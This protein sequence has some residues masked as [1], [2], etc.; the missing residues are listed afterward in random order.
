MVLVFVTRVFSYFFPLSHFHPIFFHLFTT[1]EILEQIK[2]LSEYLGY[3]VVFSTVIS[4]SSLCELTTMFVREILVI[5]FSED[6]TTT[7]VD[8][9]LKRKHTRWIRGSQLFQMKFRNQ[10][11]HIKGRLF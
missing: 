11:L 4:I 2:I 8:K 9:P 1:A 10:V 5:I 3:S 7:V 6:D